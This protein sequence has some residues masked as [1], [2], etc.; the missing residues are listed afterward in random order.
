[1]FSDLFKTLSL[2][3]ERLGYPVVAALVTIDS[4]VA[5]AFVR[6]HHEVVITTTLI[7][8]INE[9]SEAAFI[10]AHELAHIALKHGAAA[11]IDAEVAADTLA[12]KVVTALSLDPCSG[13]SV[14]ERLGRPSE[15]T[16]ASLQPRLT[17]LHDKTFDVCG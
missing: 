7:N 4:P 6:K 9:R 13:S 2:T 8:K 10:L 14:L 3:Y 16:L 5:N 1:L 11:G 15:L 17:A 12:L